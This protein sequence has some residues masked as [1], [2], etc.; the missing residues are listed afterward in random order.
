MARWGITPFP[1]NWVEVLE[2][3]Y[4]RDTYGKAARELGLQDGVDDHT[5]VKLFD[6][7]VFN[8]DD[9][10]SYLDSLTIH[11]EICIAEIALDEP[12]LKRKPKAL[13]IAA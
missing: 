13:S 5:L 10:L 9:P 2:R 11:R 1:R 8:P 7:V 4:C 3:V 6:G 12:V